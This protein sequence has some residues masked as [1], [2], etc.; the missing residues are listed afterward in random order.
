MLAFRTVRAAADGPLMTEGRNE[1]ELPYMDMG[2]GANGTP[3][4][5]EV[6][7][8]QMVYGDCAASVTYYTGGRSVRNFTWSY[9]GVQALEWQWPQPDGTAIE[10][11]VASTQQRVVAHVLGKRLLRFDRLS[12]SLRASHWDNATL[13]WNNASLGKC[14]AADVQ[15]LSA[16]GYLAATDLAPDGLVLLVRDSPEFIADSVREIALNDR[17]VFRGS[18]GSLVVAHG[19]ERWIIQNR[20]AE[21]VSARLFLAG[22]L[23]PG[24]ALSGSLV[25]S[26][27]EVRARVE[28]QDSGSVLSVDIPAQECAVLK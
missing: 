2:C 26:A 3:T 14:L 1:I 15:V 28:A 10:N 4:S 23:A 24:A 7:L 20:A 13:V 9:G 18:P 19:G 11:Y 16:V 12:A 5:D 17:I 8:W 21:P 6:P 25:P 27:R 22:P